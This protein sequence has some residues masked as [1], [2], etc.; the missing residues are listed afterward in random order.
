MQLGMQ[1]SGPIRNMKVW[2]G[3]GCYLP[4]LVSPGL[5]L[6]PKYKW[7][8]GHAGPHS[9]AHLPLPS[10]D[11]PPIC[12]HPMC[13]LDSS[14]ANTPDFLVLLLFFKLL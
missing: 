3:M 5:A 6:P 12:S 1:V 13:S 4:L 8:N 9:R 7:H 11:H 2:E 14:A 10:G